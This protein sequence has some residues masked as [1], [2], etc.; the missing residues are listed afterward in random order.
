MIVSFVS[1]AVIHPV[2]TGQR[3]AQT[4]RSCK[5]SSVCP[6]LCGR[7]VQEC[8]QGKGMCIWKDR[9]CSQKVASI[10]VAAIGEGKAAGPSVFSAAPGAAPLQ[11]LCCLCGPDVLVTEYLLTLWNCTGKCAEGF[12]LI[13]GW[14]VLWDYCSASISKVFYFTTNLLMINFREQIWCHLCDCFCLL[15]CV[16]PTVSVP[17]PFCPFCSPVTHMQSHLQH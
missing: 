17:P 14:A 8:C 16:C 9:L 13:S 2:T 3:K 11:R 15:P 7:A 5:L 10:C 1:S 12:L 4:P 6:C